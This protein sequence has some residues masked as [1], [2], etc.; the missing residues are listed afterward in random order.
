LSP[1]R[2]LILRL[3]ALGDVL[4]A[5]PLLRALK[6]GRPDAEIDWVVDPSLVPLL[7]RNPHLSQVFP[8]RPGIAKALRSRR[9]SVAIDLQNKL[10]TVALRHVL[11]AKRVLV[12]RKRSGWQALR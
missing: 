2:I 10:K 1:E 3:T 8:F 11:G 12:L 5:T 7:E 9:Y 6:L 4:L